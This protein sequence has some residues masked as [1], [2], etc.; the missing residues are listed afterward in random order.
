[1][2][3]R[4]LPTILPDLTLEESLEVTKIYSVVGDL[5]TDIPLITKRQ[6]R[7]PHHTVSD[8]GLIGGGNIPRPGEVSLAHNGVLFLDEVPEFK[9][10]VLEVLRQPMEDGSVTIARAKTS[11]RFPSRFMLIG[12]LNPC[13]CGHYGDQYHECRCTFSQIQ[14]YKSRLSGPLLDRIDIHIDVPAVEPEKL[15]KRKAGEKSITIKKRVEEARL[16]QQQ[17]FSLN[18]E[19]HCNAQMNSKLLTRYCEL[20]EESQ[21]FIERAIKSIG[22]S[23]RGSNRVLKIA[24]TIA[25]LAAVDTIKPQHVAEAIQYRRPQ[26][27]LE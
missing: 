10:H 23:A 26:Y 14:R 21:R 19:V 5:P 1:M 22:L 7:S 9:K 17:R 3:A 16:K 2:M 4:R 20:D 24:R 13:P 18:L 12:A 25:D 6:F 15:N 11:L 27:S 8:A